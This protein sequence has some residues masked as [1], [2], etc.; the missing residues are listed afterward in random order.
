MRLKT[1]LYVIAA[2]FFLTVH[3]ESADWLN[4]VEGKD[5]DMVYVDMESIRSTSSGTITVTKKV[6]PASK[7]I[8]SITSKIEM[9]CRNYKIRYLEE[10]TRLKSGKSK[11][12]AKNEEFRKVTIEDE[13]ESLMELICS[14][15]KS[16]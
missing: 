13:D 14:L 8:S 7:S 9:D 3:A 4:Y 6:E 2:L 1:C 12:A 16:R 15:K 10:T 5:G 11:T